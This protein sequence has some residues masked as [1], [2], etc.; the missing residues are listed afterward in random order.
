M[1]SNPLL[2]FFKG[3]VINTV[4]NYSVMHY[5]QHWSSPSS[6]QFNFCLFSTHRPSVSANQST[7]I[8]HGSVYIAH[9]DCMFNQ[10]TT[11]KQKYTKKSQQLSNWTLQAKNQRSHYELK[12][13]QFLPRPND[14]IYWHSFCSSGLFLHFSKWFFLGQTS[15]DNVETPSAKLRKNI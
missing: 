2:Y 6:I 14:L 5:T 3:K 4:I 12:H 11:S 1:K 7:E 10:S 15:W 9:C 13:S 8:L